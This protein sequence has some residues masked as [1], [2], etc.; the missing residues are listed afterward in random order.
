[1]GLSLDR[2]NSAFAERYRIERVL[3]AGGM[4]T[5]YAARDLKHDRVVALKI[6]HP[7][8]AV[9]VD[10]RFLR[11]IRVTAQFS[12]PGILGLIDSGSVEI[13]GQSLPYYVMP[14]V[15]G[16]SLRDRLRRERTLPAATAVSIARQIALALGYAHERGV[17]HRDVKPENVLLVGDH[18]VVADFGIAKAAGGAAGITLTAQGGLIGTPAYMSPEQATGRD[19]IGPRSDLFSLGVVLYEMLVGELPFGGTTVQSQIAR[20]LHETPVGVRVLRPE[21]PVALDRAVSR[22]LARDPSDRFPSAA[23]MATALDQSLAPP[24]G[25]TRIPAAIGGVAAVALL[26][27]AGWWAIG[28]N[29]RGG[30]D[31][32]MPRSVAVLPFA[33]VG[34]DPNNEF[35]SDGIADEIAGSLARLAGV[36]V[37]ARSSA[38][39]FKGRNVAATQVGAELSVDAVVEGSVRRSGDQVT[40]TAQLVSAADGLSLWSE[41]YQRSA[42]QAFTVQAEV[43]AAIA[44]T[45]GLGVAARPQGPGTTNRR[46]YEAF[47]QGRW[48]WSKRDQE[49][50]RQAARYFRE[51][52]EADSGFAKAWAGL[53]DT[54]SLQAG[55]GYLPVAEAFALGR[56]AANRALTLDSTLADARSSLGFIHL[57]YDWDWAAAGSRLTEALRLDPTYGEARLFYG[58]WLVATGRVNE[59][60][61]SLATAVRD[62]PL[63][64]ILNARLGSMLMLAGRYPEAERQLAHTTELA[65]NYWP[66]RLDRARILAVRGQFDS[67]AAMVSGLNELVGAYA[68][69]IRGY[70]L[71]RAGRRAEAQVEIARLSA[72]GLTATTSALGVA[73]AY[74]GLGDFDQAFQWLDRAYED[75]NWAL[76]FCRNDPLLEPLRRDPR[77]NTFVAR[78][79]FP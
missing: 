22:A 45:L 17:V 8:I 16:E 56:A 54:Y 76:F 77:W 27:A 19:E 41:S 18:A 5:V 52:I 1:M 13:D 57:F 20:R 70:A 4:A 33:N 53:G 48:H 44:R 74:T 62:E 2:L 10:D 58:W 59:A 31:R 43:T 29:R 72:G 26:A 42:E 50:F 46:A 36:R 69:G 23:A 71:G 68:S 6:L 32:A 61:D 75:R 28:P 3:G 37:A 49:G 63:S 35:Y 14:L 30:D 9:A 51:A 15:E 40:I 55:F 73:Q 66:P 47:L 65:A 64:L 39:Q 7:E 11:E 24:T 12:H 78:M 38:F 25:G 67:A 21:V 34:A 60:V 79:N